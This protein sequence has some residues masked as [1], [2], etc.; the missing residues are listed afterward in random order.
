MANKRPQKNDV[1]EIENAF[2]NLAEKNAMKKNAK[3]EKAA[4]KRKAIIISIICCVI[5]IAIAIPVCGLF[6][7]QHLHNNAVISANL[8]IAGINVAGMTREQAEK[9]VEDAAKNALAE[10]TMTV[11]VDEHIVQIPASTAAITL[12]IKAAVDAA[13]NYEQSSNSVQSLDLTPF[14]T[15]DKDSIVAQ[16][17]PL[18]SYYSST[19]VESS[20]ETVGEP[21]IDVT[22]LDETMQLPTLKITLGIPGIA[23]NID[24]LYQHILDAYNECS[25]NVEYTVSH[26]EPIAIDLN[27]LYAELSVQPVDAVMDPQTFEIT[28]GF[29]GYDFDLEA[30]TVAL[31]QATYGDTI[32]IPFKWLEP[33]ISVEK[34]GEMLFRDVL[35]TC[36]TKTNSTINRQ[37]NLKLA[38]QGINGMIIYPGETFSFNG[39]LGERTTA[40][41]YKPATAYINGESVQDVGGGICQVASTLYY[42]TVVAD[43]KI[44]ERWAHGYYSDYL[45]QSTDATV[46]WGGLDF[47]F[48]NNWEYPIKIEAIAS[49]GNVTI[50]LYGTDTKDYYVKFVSEKLS[51]TPPETVY[52]EFLADNEEGYEDGDVITTPYTGY[53]S[54]SYRVKYDKA[55]NK[56]ISST[57]ECSDRYSVRNEVICKIVDSIIDP[58]APPVPDTTV[59][60]TTVPDTTVPDTTA[61]DTTVP[62][63]TVPDTT[64]PDTTV[65]DT[66]VPTTT[67][68]PA[69]EDTGSQPADSQE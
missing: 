63:T 42:C 48:K 50:T 1:S 64:V 37:T 4:H 62:D 14:M 46:F 47:K 6:I 65:P 53:T 25:F 44:V 5:L 29:Y 43:M 26:T 35:A 56:K 12:D 8:S 61:P 40:K 58:N 28:G 68:P 41:G 23:L 49:Y 30:A 52:K 24:E 55:T 69:G 15:I 32:E 20:Y 27:A 7:S 36:T 3:I 33:E 67:A 22:A 2:H 39:A 18:S 17:T 16:L 54:R 9:A 10:N 51:E 31:T 13:V 34:A 21:P 38:C 60:D 19:L 57:L 59:P 66:T 45:P 11:T